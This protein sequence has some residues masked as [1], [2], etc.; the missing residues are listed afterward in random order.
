MDHFAFLDI[1]T[2]FSGTITVTGVF[3]PLIGS[4]QLVGDNNNKQNILEL[5]QGVKKIFTYNGSRFDFPVIQRFTGVNLGEVFE[6]RDLMFD[7]WSN[8]LYGGLKKVEMLLGISRDTEGISG[9]D[10][11]L[12][13]ES[14]IKGDR[15]S[16]EVLLRYNR[17]DVENLEVL[18]KKLNII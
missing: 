14:Y 18:A 15:E 5:L 17:E 3:R 6:H 10:A 7:C 4:R 1:E 2:S 12:L 8:N 16:L 9:Y 11:L 13:W